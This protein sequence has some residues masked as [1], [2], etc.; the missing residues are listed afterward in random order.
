MTGGPAGAAAGPGAAVPAHSLRVVVP[1]YGENV[2][3][4]AESLAR[5]LSARLAAGGRSVEVWTTCATDSSTWVNQEPPGRGRDGAV[6]VLRFPVGMRRRPRLFREL[7]RGFFRLP[8]PLRPES[9]WIIL[10]GPWTPALVRALRRGPPGATLFVGYLYHPTLAGLPVTPGLRLVLPTAHD[11]RPLRLRA[12]GRAVAAAHGIW[13]AT[14]EERELLESVHPVARSIP[15]VVGNMGI[16]PPAD[17]DPERFRRHAG[18]SGDYLF[19]GGRT[20]TG[21]GID[22]L[23]AAMAA[24]RRRVPECVLVLAGEAGDGIGQVPGVVGAGRLDR[25]TWWDALSGAAAVVVPSFLESLSILTLEAWAAAR[26]VLANAA[27]PVL[28]AQ[29]ERSGAG[30]A[31]RGAQGFVEAAARLLEDPA[32]ATALGG[33]GRAFVER[34][35][36][37]DAVLGR[38]DELLTAARRHAG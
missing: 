2:V 20:A 6:S 38:F 12:V 24:L 5:E 17:P 29:V 25:K 4:G 19:H 23:L 1:R 18:I 7:S 11:E 36:R 22:E 37:W 3:G 32:Q 30:I 9:A 28:A 16:E 31:Y 21:K 10:Q 27:S 15:S 13:Y 35:Y 14:V 26:P 33:R 8:R 34:D